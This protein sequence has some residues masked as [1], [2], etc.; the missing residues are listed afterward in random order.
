MSIWLVPF[1]FNHLVAH[2]ILCQCLMTVLDTPKLH[3]WKKSLRPANS[4]S[5]SVKEF[6]PKLDVIQEPSILIMI[7][8]SKILSR[9]LTANQKA[10]TTKPLLIRFTQWIDLF[11]LLPSTERCDRNITK[12]KVLISAVIRYKYKVDRYLEQCYSLV[13]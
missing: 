1:Q 2:A 6:I 12:Y 8:S 11:M 13:L 5:L 10:L 7:V 9:L 4:S 3:S